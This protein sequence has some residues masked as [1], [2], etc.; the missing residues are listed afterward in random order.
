MHKSRIVSAD[1]QEADVQLARWG[2]KLLQNTLT[3]AEPAAHRRAGAGAAADSGFSS[4]P[5][6]PWPPAQ[7]AAPGRKQLLRSCEAGF[8]ELTWGPSA[9]WG[10]GWSLLPPLPPQQ[11]GTWGAAA[12]LERLSD[13]LTCSPGGQDGQGGEDGSRAAALAGGP[14]GAVIVCGGC[15]EGRCLVAL[16]AAVAEGLAELLA[17]LAS[18]ADDARAGGREGGV[19]C[20]V[21]VAP[22]RHAAAGAEFA[23]EVALADPNDFLAALGLLRLEAALGGAKRLMPRLDAGHVGAG[24]RLSVRLE[25]TPS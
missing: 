25:L 15:A 10:E 6:S 22:G 16:R 8:S 19:G 18:E 12:A 14:R 3:K 23:F 21:A 17:P 2:E 5:S 4:W 11:A 24:G 1:L 7:P 9:A 13:W 20:V